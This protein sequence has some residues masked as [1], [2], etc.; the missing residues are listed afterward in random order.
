M[1]DD[2]PDAPDI[3][4]T[5]GGSEPAE[6][7]LIGSLRTAVAAAPADVPLRRG[8]PT[9]TP[10]RTPSPPRDHGLRR[11]L[12]GAVFRMLRGTRWLALLRL[13]IAVLAGRTFPTGGDP[14]ALPGPLGIRLYA[15]FRCLAP[16][17]GDAQRSSD[18]P[19][20][21][22]PA[23]RMGAADR[24]AGG[25]VHAVPWSERIVPQVLFWVALVPTLHTVWFERAAIRT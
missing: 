17:P 14:T 5:S 15:L 2:T 20:V 18:E 16:L 21:A 4:G 13:V 24:R 6:S 23:G 9:G 22:A 12:D 3:P 11:G 7:P 19:V 25:V 8:T 1:P 10:P